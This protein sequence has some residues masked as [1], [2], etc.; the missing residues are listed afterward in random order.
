MRTDLIAGELTLLQSGAYDEHWRFKV[1][2]GDGTL[3]DLSTLLKNGS[4]RL[5]DPDAPIGTAEVTLWR[6]INDDASASLS[7]LVASSFN[8]LDDEVT[9][10]PLIQIGR[11][12]TL[13]LAVTAV[14]AARPAGGSASWHE[15]IGGFVKQPSW[16]QRYGDISVEIHDRAYKLKR[17]FIESPT[18]TS[19]STTIEATI[20]AVLDDVMGSGVYPVTVDDVAGGG[21]TGSALSV[22]YLP[23]IVPV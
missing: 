3:I 6:E 4:V 12:A 16:P 9:P 14:G 10:S 15:I 11:A 8:V 18:T 13:E 20:Q 21:T 22:D 17:T 23:D 5:P 7:P 1:A 2:N 19:S